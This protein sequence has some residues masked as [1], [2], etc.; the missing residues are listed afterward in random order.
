MSEVS[1]LYESD[2]V[3]REVAD[4]LYGGGVEIHKASPDQADLNAR[5]AKSQRRQAQVGLATNVIGIGAGLAG[6][7]A[8]AKE[9]SSARESAGKKKVK[10]AP[11]HMGEG[12]IAGKLK[13]LK[14]F[15]SGKKA[16]YAVAAA[17]AGLGLQAANV[18]GDFVANRV[19][20]RSAKKDQIHKEFFGVPT[21]KKEAQLKAIN[22]GV[23]GGKKGTELGKSGLKKGKLKIC[24]MVEKSFDVTWE[25]EIS[26]VDADKQQVFGWASIVE[27]NGE[28][29]V[30][31]QGDYIAIDEVE[32]SAY[33]Y[34]HKS[35]KGGDMHLR[36]GD[37]PIHKSD[38]IESFVVTP[39]KKKAMHLPEDTPVGWWV[40]YQINDADLWQ[41]VKSG[42]RTGFSIHGRGQRS[43]A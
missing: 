6:T 16:K 34:V 14:N 11:K 29:V 35:R 24:N 23:K 21:T 10:Y 9:F 38:M 4:L 41:K 17:G 5:R 22:A 32:K 36:D 19:L 15:A 27:M 12:K 33:E 25:G 1:K 8:A 3:F 28:P 31:L 20:A 7:A 42:Q 37:Q 26:K 39:E 13:P 30:D 2:E 18:A 43:D 40:G